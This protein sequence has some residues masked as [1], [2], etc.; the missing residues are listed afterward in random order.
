[1]SVVREDDDMLAAELAFGLLDADEEAAARARIAAEPAFAAR[2]ARWVE[3]AAALFA[4]DE[5]PPRPSLWREIDG[6]LPGNDDTPAD[7]SLAARWRAASIALGVIAT[8]LGALA[9]HPG[10]PPP[11]APAPV[12][13]RVSAP[14]IAVLRADGAAATV[15]I[16]FD[17]GSNRLTLAA[18]ALDA[19]AGSAELWAIPATGTPQSLGLVDADAPTWRVSPAAARLVTPGVTLAV[20]LEPRGGSPTGRP[21]GTPLL[22]GT[23]AAAHAESVPGA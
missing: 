16:G 3:L 23:V 17:P 11:P 14:L 13:E 4:G 5:E 9:L 2:L 19:R 21:S 22:T 6:R 20:T 18:D 1:M 10:A 8:V 7:G 12:Q 15:A